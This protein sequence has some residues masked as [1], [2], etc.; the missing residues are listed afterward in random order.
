MVV[1][2]ANYEFARVDVGTNVKVFYERVSSNMEFFKRLVKNNLQIPE[3]DYLP[4][5]EIT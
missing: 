5:S 1:I 2:D 4:D 3:P